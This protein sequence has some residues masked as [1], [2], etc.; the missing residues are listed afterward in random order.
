[1]WAWVSEVGIGANRSGKCQLEAEK[2]R[3]ESGKHACHI[4]VMRGRYVLYEVNWCDMRHVS[5][6][7]NWCHMRQVDVV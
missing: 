3:E 4:S 7:V 1:M 6:E 5:Y 2:A